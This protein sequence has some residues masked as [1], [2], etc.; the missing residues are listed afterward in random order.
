[1]LIQIEELKQHIDLNT[2]EYDPVLEIYADAI[3]DFIRNYLG[4]PIEIEAITEYLNGDDLSDQVH[5]ASFPM[6]IDETDHLFTF[7]YATGP[8]SD[9]T[10]NDFDADSYQVDDEIGII[11]ADTMYAGRKNI[12][13]TYYAGYATVPNPIKLASMKLVAKVFNSR[14]SD[15]FKDE[16]LGDASISWDKFMSDDITALLAKYRRI[17]L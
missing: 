3:S 10:W 11:Y 13:V 8:Y 15:G 5:L 1:M 7:Q 16:S 4:R 2:N 6:V 17:S 9:L 12:K 14:K